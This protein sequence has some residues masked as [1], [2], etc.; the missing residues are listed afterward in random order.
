MRE[1]PQFEPSHGKGAVARATFYFLLRYPGEINRAVE[2]YEADRLSL[3]L[4]WHRQEP[5]DDYERRRNT[6]N[7]AK[8]GNRNPLIDFPEWAE[9]DFTPGLGAP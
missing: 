6:A 7:S 5:E 8:Q 4:E 1:E 3:L 2:E 9:L